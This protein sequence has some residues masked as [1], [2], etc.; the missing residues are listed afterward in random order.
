M[1]L[2]TPATFLAERTESGQV[3]RT[4]LDTGQG[5]ERG[6]IIYYVLPAEMDG[7]TK[8]QLEVLDSQGNLVRALHPK[9]EDYDQWDEKAKSLDGGPWIPTAPGVNR[10][11]WDL[12][13][14]GADQVAGSK[15][16]SE[17]RVG[18]LVTPGDV[19]GPSSRRRSGA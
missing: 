18:P 15:T 1:G 9:P 17:A 12:R 2:M 8:V 10:F 3:R 4:F 11:V 19:H 16:A 13:Y 14:P 5:A 7:Q 6:A